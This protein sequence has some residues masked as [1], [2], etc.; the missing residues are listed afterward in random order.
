[1][2]TGSMEPR[3]TRLTLRVA[4]GARRSEIVGRHGAGW[5]VRVAAAPEAGRANAALRGLLAETLDVPLRA[6]A[7]VSGAGSRDK[8]VEVEGLGPDE[9]ERRL[10][11]AT[12]PGKD[13]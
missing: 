3:S 6:V 5:K 13:A 9:T 2:D 7:V 10:A 12:A 1:M 4:P 11:T 8:L